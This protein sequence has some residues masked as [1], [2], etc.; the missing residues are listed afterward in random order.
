MKIRTFRSSNKTLYSYRAYSKNTRNGFKHVCALCVNADSN[1]YWVEDTCH[2]INRTWEC[3][4]YQSVMRVC[5]DDYKNSVIN[6]ALKR[7]KE[8]NNYQRLTAKRREEF[9]HSEYYPINEVNSIHE[10][11]RDL[12]ENHY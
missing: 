6:S 5:L 9:K 2:Y 8:A 10:A 7:F 1:S 11:E 3:Y 4:A 12:K